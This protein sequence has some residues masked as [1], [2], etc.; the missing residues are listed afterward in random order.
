MTA[1]ILLISLQAPQVSYSQIPNLNAANEVTLTQYAKRAYIA[2]RFGTP[3]PHA[4]AIE[5]KGYPDSNNSVSVKYTNIINGMMVEVKWE[6]IDSYGGS[7]VGEATIKF[8]N[9]ND[10]SNFSIYNSSFGI[11]KHRAEDLNLVRVE[12][13]DQNKEVEIG[14]FIFDKKTIHLEYKAPEFKNDS[15]VLGQFYDLDVPFFF[16]DLDFD[17]NDELIVVLRGAGQRYSDIFKVYAFKDGHLIDKQIQITDDEPYL[18][19]DG[20]ST[21]DIENKTINIHGSSGACDNFDKTYRF[22]PSKS[23]AERGKYMLEKFSLR[24][25]REEGE[26]LICHS[27]IYKADQN[28]KLT[29]I[30]KKILR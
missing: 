22:L 12:L 1:W 19:L 27:L 25:T 24:E 15:D 3:H 10:G 20:L 26:N 11:G 21:I 9:I 7:I 5:P 8:K 30:S 17:N 29:L 18:E 14:R 6:P 23:N 4:Y 28:K 2:N 16:Y 13:E